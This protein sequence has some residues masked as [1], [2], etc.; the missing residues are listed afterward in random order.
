MSGM[1]TMWARKLR[2]CQL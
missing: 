2:T 1:V